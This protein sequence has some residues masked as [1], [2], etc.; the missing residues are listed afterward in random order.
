MKKNPFFRIMKEVDL[1]GKDPDIYY[2][3]KK[4]KQHG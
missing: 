3:G 2:K 1:F 4:K